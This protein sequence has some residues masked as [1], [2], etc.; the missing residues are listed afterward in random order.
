MSSCSLLV[1]QYNLLCPAYG[2]K[3]GE[4]EACLE[5]RSK[6]DHGPSN[7]SARWPALRRVLSLCKFDIVCLQEL[8]ASTAADV[9][10]ALAD[11]GLDL[12]WFNHPGR[13]DGIGVAFNTETF[14]L[15]QSVLGSFPSA[16]P[17]VGTARLD[18]KHTAA[19]VGVRVLSTHQR[20]GN[21]EQLADLFTFAKADMREGPGIVVVCGDFNEDFASWEAPGALRPEPLAGF[22]TLDRREPEPLVSRPPHKLDPALNSSGRGKV[23][24]IF[25]APHDAPAAHADIKL[26]RSQEAL[27]ALWASHAACEETGEWPSDHG[28]EALAIHVTLPH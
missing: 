5:W 2:V 8:E 19:G 11:Q 14:T 10:A 17:T 1:G 15:S 9:T 13:A 12:V 18:L 26:E 3:W 22:A 4:R 28:M 6:E 23:D 16:N 27:R 20:G 7:W 25:V 21:R 24:Y